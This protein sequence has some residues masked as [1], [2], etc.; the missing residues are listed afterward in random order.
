MN[1][2]SS[3]IR[4]SSL[5]SPDPAF[6]NTCSVALR[7]SQ[8][9]PSLCNSRS[10]HSSP[11]VPGVYILTWLSEWG[12]KTK[13]NKHCSVSQSCLTLCNPMHCSMPGF[14]VLHHCIV[15]DTRPWS[16]TRWGLFSKLFVACGSE[17]LLP[18]QYKLR[19]NS[20]DSHFLLI[21]HEIQAGE[22]L[23]FCEGKAR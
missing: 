21:P 19:H 16:E 13:L 2:N 7:I 18:N 8:G 1:T 3:S 11:I 9:W 4:N 5:H 14:P 12:K 17:H 22:V 6:P 15:R 10:S 20:F 23:I